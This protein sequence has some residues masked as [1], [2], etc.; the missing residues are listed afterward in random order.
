MWRACQWWGKTILMTLHNYGAIALKDWRAVNCNHSLSNNHSSKTYLLGSWSYQNSA[1]Q[2]IT[3]V[4]SVVV[5]YIVGIYNWQTDYYFILL[6]RFWRR[7]C[8]WFRK[9]QYGQSRDW[10]GDW[11]TFRWPVW[12]KPFIWWISAHRLIDTLFIS[13]M[14]TLNHV[15]AVLLYL[16][17]QLMVQVCELMIYVAF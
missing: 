14:Y 17:D 11:T 12:Y 5:Q 9:I 4:C 8:S 15:L 6:C 3:S 16:G 13:G 10:T 1:A 2:I 7:V